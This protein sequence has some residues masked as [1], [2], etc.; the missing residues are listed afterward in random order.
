MT[1]LSLKLAT[2]FA[3]T[4]MSIAPAISGELTPVGQWQT[5]GGE[6]HYE[7]SLCGDGTKLCAKLTWL[8]P[9]A[10]TDEN[11]KYLNRYVLSGAE[12]TSANRWRG[13]VRYGDDVFGGSVTLVNAERLKLNG[14]MGIFCQSMEFERL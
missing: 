13:A 11:L 12:Q 14:C 2:L 8:R 4:A 1:K 6:S 10:R 7:I 9:D 3:M 5:T